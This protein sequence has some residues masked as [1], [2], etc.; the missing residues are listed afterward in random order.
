MSISSISTTNP[1]TIKAKV[2]NI[3]LFICF[4]CTSLI[5]ILPQTTYGNEINRCIGEASNKYNVPKK[6]IELIAYNLEGGKKGM[7]NLNS[8][9]TYDMGIMQINSIHLNEFKKYGIKEN[10][11]INNICTNIDAGTFLLA[12][13]IIR[14]KSFAKGISNYH[15]RTEKHATKYLKKAALALESEND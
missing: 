13:E 1:L 10:D 12:R 11:L 14:T 9:N 3:K 15:S 2:A 4:S 7:K 5:L 6:I 8:N